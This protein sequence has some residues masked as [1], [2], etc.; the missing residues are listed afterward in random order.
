MNDRQ[1][2]SARLDRDEKLNALYAANGEQAP[3]PP[4]ESPPAPAG[5]RKALN[6]CLLLAI[7]WWVIGF[8]IYGF[9]KFLTA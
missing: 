6:G 2:A 4:V 3:L 7:L 5:C 8:A 9:Y 1:L